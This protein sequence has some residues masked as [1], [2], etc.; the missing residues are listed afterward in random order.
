MLM[1]GVGSK[2]HRLTTAMVKVDSTVGGSRCRTR[3]GVL[4]RIGCLDVP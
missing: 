3:G 1:R 2:V 4:R